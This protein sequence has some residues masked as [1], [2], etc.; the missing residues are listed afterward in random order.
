MKFFYDIYGQLY[1]PLCGF[2]LLQEEYYDH[3]YNCPKCGEKIEKDTESDKDNEVLMHQALDSDTRNSDNYKRLKQNFD[4]IFNDK[5]SEN[6][7]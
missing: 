4:A 5:E 7:A 6:N 1:C 2:I 3:I